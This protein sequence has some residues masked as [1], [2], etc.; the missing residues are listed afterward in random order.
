MEGIARIPVAPISY[1]A[2]AALL[3]GLRGTDLPEQNWQGGLP[4]RYHLGPGPVQARVVVD[5]ER[6]E[7]AYHTI[8]NTLAFLR[9]A[10]YPDEWIGTPQWW[11]RF[12]QI[13]HSCSLHSIS[14]SGLLL[15]LVSARLKDGIINCCLDAVKR[16]SLNL[17]RNFHKY[18]R[19]HLSID[20]TKNIS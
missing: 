1:G 3:E 9:G 18:A 10:A 14:N 15:Y 16:F 17:A 19:S 6:G 13:G 4:F 20:S 12:D 11:T 7:D 2:A 5:T 8:Y